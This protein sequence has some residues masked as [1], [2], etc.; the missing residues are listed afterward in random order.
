MSEIALKVAGI[1]F[2]KVFNEVVD[3]LIR[4]SVHFKS[5]KKVNVIDSYNKARNVQNV[6]TIWQF[7]KSVNLNEFYYPSKVR[8]NNKIITVKNINT[9]GEHSKIIIQGTAGQGKSILLRYLAGDALENGIKIPIFIELRKIS[10]TNNIEKL[11]L[12]AFHDLGLDIDRTL[13]NI[14]LKTGKFSLLLDAFDEIEE[15][16]VKDTLTYIE[17]MLLPIKNLNMIITSRPDS[18]VQKIFSIDVIKLEK[19]TEKDF[20]PLLKRLFSKNTEKVEETLNAINNSSTEIKKLLTTPLMLTLLVIT[21]RSYNR[22]PEQLHVFYDSLFHLL[23]TRHDET[24]PAFTRKYQCDLNKD[25]LERLFCAFCFS[26]MIM[27]SQKNSLTYSQVNKILHKAER[28]IEKESIPTSSFLSDCTKNTCLILKDG[29]DYHFIHKSVKEF[30]AAKFIVSLP[31]KLKRNFYTEA[32]DN[33]IKYRQELNFL[34]VMDEYYYNIFYYLPLIDK[35][36]FEIGFDGS[37][38]DYNFNISDICEIFINRKEHSATIRTSY[39]G[40]LFSTS[41]VSLEVSSELKEYIVDK[42]FYSDLK[43]E[44]NTESIVNDLNLKQD[45]YDFLLN[46]LQTKKLEYSD[47]EQ[48]ISNRTSTLLDLFSEVR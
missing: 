19:L 44:L 13:I 24:K 48:R 7:E 47:I 40:I 5:L 16:K 12:N 17:T 27:E 26:T 38:F 25:E 15:S 32:L 30:H 22:I 46:C 14:L 31:E 10:K 37:K 1:A 8:F 33:Y 39:P 11:I 21:Y 35:L 29:L 20:L 6:K 23:A 18:E 45:I 4:N 41:V 34:S 42:V 2:A 36:F 43:G 28:L 9:L 3:E